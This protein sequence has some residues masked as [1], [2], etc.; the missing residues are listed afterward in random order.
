[1]S[2]NTETHPSTSTAENSTPVGRKNSYS[3]MRWSAF[4]AWQAHVR[5]SAATIGVAFAERQ[6]RDL[7]RTIVPG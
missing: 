6:D 1:M 4:D 7:R 2:F 5:K 3:R